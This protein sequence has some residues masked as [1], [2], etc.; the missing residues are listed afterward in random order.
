M[1]FILTLYMKY[2]VSNLAL[3]PKFLNLAFFSKLVL[4]IF[5]IIK[6]GEK[7]NNLEFKQKL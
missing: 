7:K 1:V 6:S 2:F 3:F 5:F 4:I